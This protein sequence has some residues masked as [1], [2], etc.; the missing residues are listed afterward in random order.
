MK[1]EQSEQQNA[2]N[3]SVLLFLLNMVTDAKQE[4]M[5]EQKKKF[6]IQEEDLERLE[7]LINSSNQTPALIP[8][9]TN[10]FINS[11]NVF[12]RILEAIDLESFC[13]SILNHAEFLK[14]SKLLR[15]S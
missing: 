2:L 13:R 11:N 1:F 6:D 5:Q 10:E 12:G 14:N 7:N 3:L 8:K 15:V 4:N 9:Y